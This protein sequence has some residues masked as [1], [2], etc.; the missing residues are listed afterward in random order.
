MKGKR[1]IGEREERE[2]YNKGRHMKGKR[3]VGRQQKGKRI[4]KGDKGNGKIVIGETAE[5]EKD[6]KE[7]QMKGREDNN[8]GREIEGEETEKG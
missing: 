5:K 7:R 1:T 6:N 4:I 8:L 3:K 2:K